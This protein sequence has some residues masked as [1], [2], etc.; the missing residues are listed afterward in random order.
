MVASPDLRSRLR[1]AIW[2]AFTADAYCLGSHWIYDASAF[3]A[4]FPQG[5]RGFD[6]P[7]AGHYHAGK[8]SGALTHYGEDALVLLRSLVENGGLD[9]V[10][11]GEALIAFHTGRG[12]RSYVDKPTRQL[13]ERRR[14][15]P[16]ETAYGDEAALADEQNVTT[17]R[18]APVVVRYAG[19]P[20]L[21]LHVE[22]V[23][24]VLQNSDRTV[25]YACAQAKLLADLLAGTP[26]A[27][28]V[29]RLRSLADARTPLGLELRQM[30]DDVHA[31]RD[32]DVDAATE[33]FGRACGLTKAFPAAL[34]NALAH[35]H[36]FAAAIAACAR[37]R[38]DNASRAMLIGSWLG[39]ALGEAAIPEAWRAELVDG[40]T[41]HDLVERLVEQAEADPVAA[42]RRH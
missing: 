33:R 10:A 1:G 18:L 32:L 13:I 6:E 28:A 36:D 11:Y 23:T 27:V 41:L 31:A 8:T 5:P 7:V 40:P 37:A 17:S 39:A 19:S 34:H 24:R 2:G 20:A 21:M 3:A 29:D 30:I 12:S 35:G 25:A 38:G 16:P 9:P 26:L 42:G 14:S 4:R 15:Q 22:R